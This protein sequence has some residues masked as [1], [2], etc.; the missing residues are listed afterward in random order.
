MERCYATKCKTVLNAWIIRLEGRF[1]RLGPRPRA[2]APNCLVLDLQ[3]PGLSGL[4]LQ[5]SHQHELF[6]A[7][8]G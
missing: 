6:F 7:L 4:D 1:I 3:V 2:E 8:L 5:N